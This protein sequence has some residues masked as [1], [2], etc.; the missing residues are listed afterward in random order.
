VYVWSRPEL[1]F[2]VGFAV[3]G[4]KV[5]TWPARVIA[6]AGTTVIVAFQV[7]GRPDFDFWKHSIYLIY[8]LAPVAALTWLRV[9]QTSGTW[10]VVA[11]AVPAAV[12]FWFLPRTEIAAS[13][14]VDF[15]PNLN[16]S[17]DAVATHAN[18]PAEIL[19]DD[20][21]L[22]YYLYGRIPMDVQVGP[23]AFAYRG[24]E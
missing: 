9:P 16:P 3:T 18:G 22:R 13:H 2:L 11:M 1:W 15:Y 17:L 19:M 8:F 4:W 12:A 24:I 23:F 6:V 14:L 7:M 10:K 5:A 20:T 21:S